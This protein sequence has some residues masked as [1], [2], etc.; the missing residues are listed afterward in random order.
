MALLSYW[1]KKLKQKLRTGTYRAHGG[2]KCV[3]NPVA[4]SPQTNCTEWRNLVPNFADRG[5]SR[6]Q[7]GGS[8]TVVN[9]SFLERS[10]YF[11]FK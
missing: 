4:F 1:L 11:S 6:D 3:P 10:R 2:L 9:L 8:P 7:R 5:V